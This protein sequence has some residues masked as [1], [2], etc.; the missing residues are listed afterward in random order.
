MDRFIECQSLSSVI[1]I[2][3]Y[4]ELIFESQKDDLNYIASH[5]L[6]TTSARFFFCEAIKKLN[7]SGKLTLFVLL[8][9]IARKLHK[10]KCPIQ[11]KHAREL[12][13]KNELILSMEFAL[14]IFK[15]L[16]CNFKK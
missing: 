5:M 8:A 3:K 7:P 10:Q 4:A 9:Y 14:C 6:I 15:E 11:V 1:N 2:A 16:A 12:C 13:Y